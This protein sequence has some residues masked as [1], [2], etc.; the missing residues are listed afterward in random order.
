MST[1]VGRSD[2]LKERSFGEL[3]KDLSSEISTLVRKE[4]ELFR[5][6]MRE[7]GRIA[8][9]GL[10]MF[11]AAGIAGLAA[12][13]ATTAFA[14]LVLDTFMPAWL[15]AL[16]VAAVLGVAA[17]LLGMRGKQRVE[18]VGT[19]VPE[20]TVESVKEDVEWAKTQAKSGRR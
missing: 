12:A 9:P 10:A 5:A 18:E 16:I 2:E 11:G 1:D 8:A 13:G 4:L 19:P 3:A 6:E 14:I 17:A 7:K 20:Q 15:A